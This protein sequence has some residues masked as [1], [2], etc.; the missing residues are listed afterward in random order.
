[1][2]DERVGNFPRLEDSLSWDPYGI[3]F[4]AGGSTYPYVIDGD[5]TCASQQAG[6]RVETGRGLAVALLG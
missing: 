6:D 3:S 5:A 2:L 4:F 1:M